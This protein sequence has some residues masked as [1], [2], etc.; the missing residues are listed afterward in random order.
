MK[1]RL[2]YAGDEF[3]PF[4]HA[5]RDSQ[6]TEPAR[7][8]GYENLDAAFEKNWRR[9]LQVGLRLRSKRAERDAFDCAQDKSAFRAG[10]GFWR[11]CCETITLMHK[12]DGLR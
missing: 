1:R 11:T 5:K 8:Q 7:R 6:T 4:R 12:K 9:A 3:P 10:A 2:F